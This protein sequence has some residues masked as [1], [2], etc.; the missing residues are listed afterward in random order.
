MISLIIGAPN[1]KTIAEVHLKLNSNAASVQSNLICGTLGLLQLIVSPAVYATL[2]STDFISPLHPSAD[3]T[4]PSIALVPQIT[5]LRYTHDVTTAVFNEY[6]QTDKAL[7]QI[8][9]DDV[10]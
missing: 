9:I 6:N 4:I 1:Y 7:R 8:P 2:L 3:P 10:N 5:N